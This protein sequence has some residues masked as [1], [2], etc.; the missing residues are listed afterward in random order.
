MKK[1]F[2]LILLFIISINAF[3]QS[4]IKQNEYKPEK[5]KNVNFSDWKLSNEGCF[6]CASFYW[7]VM[8][9]PIPDKDGFYYYYIYFYSNSFY[10]SGDY[11]STFVFG[12]NLNIDGSFL[13]KLPIFISFK[14]EHSPQLLWFK[15]KNPNPSIIL[16]WTGVKVI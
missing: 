12:V 8:K 15:T 9:N 7:K 6:G 5:E 4:F 13:L 14:E 16:K 10:K 11:A 2:I 1:I 3:S